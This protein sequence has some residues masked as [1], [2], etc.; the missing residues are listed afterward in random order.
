ANGDLDEAGRLA[1]ALLA[2]DPQNPDALQLGGRVA[3][4]QKRPQVAIDR[5]RRAAMQ[6]PR[7]AALIADFGRALEAAGRRGDAEQALH[8]A[9]TLNPAATAH[10]VALG[11]LLVR[12]ARD[13]EAAEI[14]RD[15][16]RREPKNAAAHARLA[17]LELGLML[18]REAIASAEHALA[19]DPDNLV[20]LGALG[21]ALDTTGRYDE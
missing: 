6:R 21:S 8:A 10:A 1:D 4:A 3:L 5:L 20:A 2:L 13:D 11:E 7:D 16:V 12:A 17:Q 9:M 14:F 15:I 18:P 19:L